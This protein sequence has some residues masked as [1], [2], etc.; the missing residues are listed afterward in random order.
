[1][2]NSE[3]QP[4][5][6]NAEKME[7]G[8]KG[9]FS[10]GSCAKYPRQGYRQPSDPSLSDEFEVSTGQGARLRADSFRHAGSRMVVTPGGHR[11]HRHHHSHLPVPQAGGGGGGGSFWTSYLF[12]FLLFVAMVIFVV[13]A[14]T[15]ARIRSHAESVP[16]YRWSPNLKMFALAVPTVFLGVALFFLR[17]QRQ[18]SRLN[19]RRKKLR[20]ACSALA[21]L[22]VLG[23]VAAELLYKYQYKANISLF[24]EKPAQSAVSGKL[25]MYFILAVGATAAAKV[26]NGLI[27][28]P[29]RRGK[30]NK[31]KNHHHS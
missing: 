17:E 9:S 19:E 20:L 10:S 12:H 28:H 30:K 18:L 13:I 5:I 29:Y 22:L 21:G 16:E 14:A 1:M 2:S 27:G 26:V 24:Q 31:I 7:T 15:S 3:N 11:R 23:G 6:G 8:G 4:D 25:L